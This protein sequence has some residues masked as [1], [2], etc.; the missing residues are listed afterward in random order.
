MLGL[1]VRVRVRVRVT[2][3]AR[4]NSIIE[5]SQASLPSASR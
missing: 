3:L 2:S 5:Y 1:R 4:A